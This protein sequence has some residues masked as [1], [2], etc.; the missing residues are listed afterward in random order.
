MASC[1]QTAAHWPQSMHRW[2]RA[3]QTCVIFPSPVSRGSV[4]G[5]YRGQMRPQVPQALQRDWSMTIM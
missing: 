5:T 2:R 1:W 4:S 3:S